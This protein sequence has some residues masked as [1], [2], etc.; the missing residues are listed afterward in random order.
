MRPW[1]VLGS[2][3]P[4]NRRR[5]LSA[6]AGAFGAAGCRL[7]RHPPPMA[8]ATHGSSTA[9]RPATRSPTRSSCG[10][11]SPRPPTPPPAPASARP[12]TCTG[13]SRATATSATSSIVV[14][15]PPVRVA[16]I[17]PTH[18]RPHRIRRR[19]RSTPAPSEYGRRPSRSDP[20]APRLRV[21]IG[22]PLRRAISA[23]GQSDCVS[24]AREAYA[25]DPVSHRSP[26]ASR[27]SG[28]PDRRTRHRLRAGRDL[29]RPHRIA[30]R[31]D[32][33]G[34]GLDRH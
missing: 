3:S 2:V 16:A 10:P 15:G 14:A 27:A 29:A 22:P 34:V 26:P 31:P 21:F 24:R 25:G 5:F 33:P 1:I 7:R 28:G 9:S 6:S 23:R 20:F 12:W 19:G 4:L 11:A 32:A 8:K 13:R 17:G 30:P 18:A